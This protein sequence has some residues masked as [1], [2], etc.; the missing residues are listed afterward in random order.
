MYCSKKELREIESL[1]KNHF[2]NSTEV[3]N[4]F[5]DRDI[6]ETILETLKP[7]TEQKTF[8]TWKMHNNKEFK[9]DLKILPK[10]TN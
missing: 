8:T 3:K 2:K 4:I 10:K 5:T 6:L 1:I 9:K 7:Y